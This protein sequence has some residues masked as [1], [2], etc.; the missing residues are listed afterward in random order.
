VKRGKIIWARTHPKRI[1]RLS[2]DIGSTGIGLARFYC[3]TK[4]SGPTSD[5]KICWHDP[6]NP[7]G[8]MVVGRIKV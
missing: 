5:T 7:H 8:S 2:G 6:K 3:T 1:Y 4:I